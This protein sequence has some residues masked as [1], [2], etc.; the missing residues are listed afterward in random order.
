[1]TLAKTGL[2]CILNIDLNYLIDLTTFMEFPKL[3]NSLTQIGKKEYLQLSVLPKFPL[4]CFYL[5]LAFDN[6]VKAKTKTC[7]ESL[8]QRFLYV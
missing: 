3:F 2:H 1:M 5:Q 8:P 4:S 7:L 6:Y